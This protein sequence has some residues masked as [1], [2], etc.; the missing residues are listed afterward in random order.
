[1]SHSRSYFMK[2]VFRNLQKHLKPTSIPSIRLQEIHHL[3][4]FA[5]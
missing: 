1:M 4:V 2:P 3:C 5:F